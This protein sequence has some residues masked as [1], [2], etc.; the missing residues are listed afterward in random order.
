ME[1]KTY[2]INQK[3]YQLKDKYSLSDWGEI[4]KIIGALGNDNE[5]NSMVMLLADNKLQE[6][7]NV[8][9]DKPVDTVIYEDD[10]KAVSDAVN[11]FFTRKKSLI[12]GMK[13]SSPS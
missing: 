11:D 10:F 6:L 2:T 5:F 12:K 4:I 9:L 3:Q 8:I 1:T 13:N 7:L